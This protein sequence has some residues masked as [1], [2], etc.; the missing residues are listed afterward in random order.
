[1][2]KSLLLAGFFWATA[3]V[4]PLPTVGPPTVVA[5]TLAQ[6]NSGVAASAPA[7]NTPVL[8]ASA[9]RPL[10]S[11]EARLVWEMPTPMPTPVQAAPASPNALATEEQEFIEKVNAER[12]VR[13]LNALS[14]DPLLVRTARAHS[15]EMC[16]QDYFDHHSPT[17]G[18]ATPMDRYLKGLHDMG[19]GR[20]IPC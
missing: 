13:G 19:G 7:F 2:L 14:V 17:P 3:N 5:N 18:L 15:R 1:M 12:T 9:P 8:M 4:M 11:P 6:T 10:R 20:R 16:A